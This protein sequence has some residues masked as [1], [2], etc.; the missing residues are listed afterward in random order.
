M[1][2]ENPF[3]IGY[4]K[5]PYE[6]HLPSVQDFIDPSWDKAEREKIVNYLNTEKF[7]LIILRNF[8]IKSK[9]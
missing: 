5:S 2:T 4:W 6:S 1:I 8:K 9:I 3:R 7:I